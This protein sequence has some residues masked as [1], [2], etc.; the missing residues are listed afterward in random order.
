ML[1]ANSFYII[2]ILIVW[3][4]LCLIINTDLDTLEC[5]SEC[6]DNKERIESA[7]LKLPAVWRSLD[8]YVD[9]SSIE[10]IELGTKQYPYRSLKSA[11]F[12]ILNFFSH[13]DKDIFIYMKDSYI[14]DGNSNYF[15]MSSVTVQSHPDVLANGRKAMLVPTSIYQPSLMDKTLF[16]LLSLPDELS[17]SHQ[18]SYKTF[19]IIG[20]GTFT[21]IELGLLLIE[22]LSIR[23]VRTSFSLL[24][25][26]IYSESSKAQD[27]RLFLIPIYLQ[28]KSLK[29][30][31]TKWFI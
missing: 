30:G 24:D 31:K 16:Q 13:S 19:E 3:W 23:A 20:V 18:I 8:Y 12:E 22:D 14:E 21:D 2:P 7:F 10:N 11:N 9:P 15:N 28:T 1:Q 17:F 4:L 25:I 27:E 6:D 5:T 26:D 29:I